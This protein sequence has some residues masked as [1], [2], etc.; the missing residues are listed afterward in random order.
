M[1]DQNNNNTLNNNQT[2]GSA[3]NFNVPNTDNT[4]NNTQIVNNNVPEASIQQ[5]PVSAGAM[6]FSVPNTDNVANNPQIVS[7]NA[8]EPSIQQT[9]VSAG[10]MNFSVP[11]A[12]N[13]DNNGQVVN[14]TVLGNNLTQIPNVSEVGN[15]IP[16]DNNQMDNSQILNVSSPVPSAVNFNVSNQNDGTEQNMVSNVSLG[17]ISNTVNEPTQVQANTINRQGNMLENSNQ[18]ASNNISQVQELPTNTNANVGSGLEEGEKTKKKTSPVVIIALILVIFVGLAA[19]YYFVLETPKKVFGTAY[20]KL[21]SSIKDTKIVSD[22]YVNY[23]LSFN[24]STEDETVKPYVDV[25]N[26]ISMNG[27]SGYNST[28][29]TFATNGMILYKNNELLNL[30]LLLNGNTNISYVKFNNL[31]DKVLMIKPDPES[32]DNGTVSSSFNNDFGDYIELRD[33]ILNAL[34]KT[35]ENANY[36]KE[37]VDFNGSKATK[38]TLFVDKKF[39]QEFYNNLQ[40]DGSFIKNYAKV[41]NSTEDEAKADLSKQVTEFKDNNEQIIVYTSLI[42]NDFLRLEFDS[43]TSNLIVSKNSNNYNYEYKENNTLKYNG[44]INVKQ[45]ADET[46][47]NVSVNMVEEKVNL[48]INCTYSKADSVNTLDIVNAVGIDELSETETN[49]LTSKLTSNNAFK[50][51]LGDLGLDEESV[52]SLESMI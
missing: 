26:Q 41:N 1:N 22:N 51:L 10:A 28:D 48:S 11:S 38:S 40:Q 13:V 20:D 19:G 7:N 46:T 17:T 31:L 33:S 3:M 43:S 32:S 23:D 18:I 15:Q 45:V 37:L 30:S 27:T 47:L 8:P 9:P 52:S 44:V 6:N 12:N 34:K 29:K 16:Q 14:N 25:I 21:L 35:L 2:I 5:A 49:E 4:V 36:K 50:E 42:K 39:I 24:I